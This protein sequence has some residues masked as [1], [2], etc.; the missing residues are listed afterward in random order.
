MVFD[1]SSDYDMWTLLKYHSWSIFKAFPLPE[2]SSLSK[3]LLPI[4]LLS[5]VGPEIHPDGWDWTSVISSPARPQAVGQDP[6]QVLGLPVNGPGWSAS[7]F[8][9]VLLGKK[10]EA[11][12]R[13]SSHTPQPERSWEWRPPTSSVLLWWCIDLVVVTTAVAEAVHRESWG[14]AASPAGH[15]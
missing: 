7:S 5:T 9:K 4:I 8:N 1:F 13:W 14:W 11:T 2:K 10:K 15:S 6:E 12:L 3:F